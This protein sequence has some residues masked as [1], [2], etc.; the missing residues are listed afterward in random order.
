MESDLKSALLQAGNGREDPA[1]GGRRCGAVGDIFWKIS[2]TV[3]LQPDR[4]T[5][6]IYHSLQSEPESECHPAAQTAWFILPNLMQR[7]VLVC[8]N[9]YLSGG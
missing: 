7:V 3:I 2:S 6:I 1:G 4:T 8:H 9:S 5:D